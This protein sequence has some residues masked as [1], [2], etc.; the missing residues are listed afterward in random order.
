[1]RLPAL[2]LIVV[3]AAVGWLAAG[4]LAGW[5]RPVA[6]LALAG[7]GALLA[8]QGWLRRVVGVLIVLAGAGLLASGGLWPAV[9]GAAV[10]AGGLLVLRFG[11]DWPGM[12]A[13]YERPGPAVGSGPATAGEPLSTQDTWAALDRGEDPTEDPALD[14]R[15]ASGDGPVDGGPA[16]EGREPR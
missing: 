6:L 8:V 11:G 13:R 3:G 1:M 14:E 10:M 7:A 2:A 16:G 15:P 5:V 4:A 12:A 9:G